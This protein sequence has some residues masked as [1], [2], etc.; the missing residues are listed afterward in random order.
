MAIWVLVDRIGDRVNVIWW[1]VS[2]TQR[3][4]QESQDKGNNNNN[5]LKEEEE[6]RYAHII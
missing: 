5:E 6:K 1:N 4:R 3:R 2:E